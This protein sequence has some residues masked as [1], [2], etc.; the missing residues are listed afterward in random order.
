MITKNNERQPISFES[1]SGDLFKNVIF[2]EFEPLC[3]KVSAFMSN[4]PKILTKYGH[5]T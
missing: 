2:I 1:F 3:Q 4:L 5:V